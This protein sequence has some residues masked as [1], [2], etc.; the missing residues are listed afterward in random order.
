[1]PIMKHL[2]CFPS[3]SR[4]LQRRVNTRRMAA[5][6]FVALGVLVASAPDLSAKRGG[7]GGGGHHHTRP[8]AVYERRSLEFGDIAGSSEGSGTATISTTGGKSTTGFAI[9]MGGRVRAAEFKVT[10]PRNT[11]VNITL[12]SSITVTN[13]SGQT[14]TIHSFTSDPSGTGTLNNHGKLEIHVGATI[15]VPANQAGGDYTGSFTIT[16][17]DPLNP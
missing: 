8:V 5:A 1:M 10:G 16:V 2:S 15:D 4:L 3:A 12:P 13:G 9:D 11:Q 7:G 6:A 17:V 14:T